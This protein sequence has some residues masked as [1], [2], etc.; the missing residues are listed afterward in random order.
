MKLIWHI[1]KKDLRRLWLLLLGWGAIIVVQF[2]GFRLNRLGAEDERHHSVMFFWILHLVAGWLLVP[3]LVHDDPLLAEAAGWRVRPISGARL[4]A[5]KLFGF[6]V[7]LCLWPSVFTTLWW[8]DI[9]MG[10]GEIVRAVAVNTLGMGIVLGTALL[11]AMQTDNLARFLAWSLV[12]VVAAGLGGLVLAAGLQS[13]GIGPVDASVLVTRATLAI[14]LILLTTLVVVPLQYLCRRPALARGVTAGAVIA[15]ALVVQVWPWSRAQ[16]QS[17]T[18]LK[19]YS[20]PAATARPGASTLY[21]PSDSAKQKVSVRVGVDYEVKNRVPGDDIWLVD[22]V[23]RWRFGENRLAQMPATGMSV[24]PLGFRSVAQELAG[25]GALKIE[26]IWRPGM[27]MELPG[28][29][30]PRLRNGEGAVS[31]SSRAA[32]WRGEAFPPLVLHEN[33]RSG[34]AAGLRQFHVN[35]LASGGD[36]VWSR[37]ENSMFWFEIAPLF[38]PAEYLGLLNPDGAGSHQFTSAL[39]NSGKE[40][41]FAD[42][43]GF[44]YA[45]RS[46]YLPRGGVPVGVMSLILRTSDQHQE[47]WYRGDDD[48]Y[49]NGDRGG[50]QL[51]RSSLPLEGATLT[52]VGFHDAAPLSVAMP[53]TAF[54][55]DL[56]VE[57]RVDDALRRAQA[58]GKLVVVHVAVPT[59]EENQRAARQLRLTTAGR[60]FLQSNYICVETTWDDAGTLRRASDDTHSGMIVILKAD[61][62][63]QD[64]LRDLVGPD[65]LNALQANVAGK[66][67][68]TFLTEALAAAGG[69]DRALRYDLHNALRARGELSGAFDAVLWL[70]D[71]PPSSSDDILFSQIGW[72]IQKFV[73]IYPPARATLLERREQAVANLRRDPRD[74]GAARLLYTITLGLQHDTTIWMDFPRVLPHD[75]PLWWEYMRHWLAR[76]VAQKNYAEA[77][78]ATNLEKFFAEGPA[79]VRAQLMAKRPAN[80]GEPP[81]A[82]SEWQKRLVRAG[83]ICVEALAKSGQPDAALRVARAVVR[84]D[85]AKGT[86]DGAFWALYN[87]GAKMQAH[88]LTKPN[89]YVPE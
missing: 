37:N 24:R 14:G 11:I 30:A 20:L 29:L 78:A 35:G 4:L 57:G 23:R 2:I 68:A 84:V 40:S 65:L 58:E 64:R 27:Y 67:Y 80:P 39:L 48:G 17:W 76:T 51:R 74:E 59:K 8:L 22:S 16:M 75:N 33:S 38:T 69:N 15:A 13:N 66:N 60:E 81:A 87:A 12:A 53:E 54:V 25:G 70:V 45:E 62:Q 63:E 36:W 83:L 6:V 89:F 46:N 9:G 34:S 72:R 44:F 28:V 47:Q 73:E 56:I 82:V 50:W 10:F 41:A 1:F 52:L 32:V 19:R 86:A 49:E 42:G 88:Q 77:A 79:W 43:P 31:V 71:H 21:M 26:N 85:T 18:G 3:R 55:P 5:A 7:L 61:G